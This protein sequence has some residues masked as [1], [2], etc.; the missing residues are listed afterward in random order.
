[1]ASTPGGMVMT[2]AFAVWRLITNS[3]LVG[4]STGRSV[5]FAPRNFADVVSGAGTGPGSFVGCRKGLDLTRFMSVPCHHL[6]PSSSERVRQG[7]RIEKGAF[8]N[9]S[10]PQG[11]GPELDEAVVD[12]PRQIVFTAGLVEH[13][14]GHFTE[15]LQDRIV[16]LADLNRRIVG[17][18]LQRDSVVRGEIRV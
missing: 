18:L 9:V 14:A 12:S 3:N 4:C 7:A 15:R 11:R 16:E 13:F 1:M 6:R 17:D 10:P 2:N 8:R 5:G